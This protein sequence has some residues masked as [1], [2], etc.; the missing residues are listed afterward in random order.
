MTSEANAE[1]FRINGSGGVRNKMM[2]KQ[3]RTSPSSRSSSSSSAESSEAAVHNR[4]CA[5]TELEYRKFEEEQ[6]FYVV[7]RPLGSTFVSDNNPVMT[8]HFM[9]HGEGT[10]N[11]AAERAAKVGIRCH[12]EEEP[13]SPPLLR[14]VRTVIPPS[15]T[16][17]LP[18]KAGNKP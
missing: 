3:P 13:M 16:P 11:A 12:C 4:K 1:K 15:L 8:V 17:F 2:K 9:R 5:E 14:R 7:L 10:H 6:D 18:P